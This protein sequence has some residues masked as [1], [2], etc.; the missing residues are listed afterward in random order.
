[1]SLFIENIAY[2]PFTYEWAVDAERQHAEDMHWSTKQVDLS[3]DLRQFTSEGGLETKDVT[4]ES[5]KNMLE[6]LIMLFTE[7]DVVVGN[8]Y[9]KLLP[10]IK[11]NEI[12]TLWFTFAAREV[13]H[14]RGY[15]LAAETFGYTNSDWA[16]FKEYKEMQDKIDLLGKDIGNLDKKINFAKQLAVILLG[17]GIALFGA[18]A[19]LLNLRRFGL[20]QNFNS[21]NEWSLKDEQEHVVNNIKI[22]NECRKELNAKEKKE[23]NVFIKDITEEFVTAENKFIDLIYDMGPQQDMSIKDT[24]DFISYLR[25]L[26]LNQLGIIEASEV[27]ENPLDWIDYILTG[28]TH[29]NFFEAKVIDYSHN[30]LGTVEYDK[31]ITSIKE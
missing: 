24:K 28:S 16:E 3:D 11:N 4:H 15:A 25:E 2:R 8:G 23:L 22:L 26:R 10:Y 9:A 27:R 20:M 1:M 21:I 5:N 17:E 7:M 19:C 31:Y 18:F 29:T 13:T 12:R 14:Q 30:D 6:K